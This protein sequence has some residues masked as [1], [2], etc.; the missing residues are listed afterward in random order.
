MEKFLD[1]IVGFGGSAS[2]PA[3]TT[4]A[5]KFAKYFKLYYASDK[6]EIVNEQENF[7]AALTRL[8][9]GVSYDSTHLGIRTGP[10]GISG[11]ALIKQHFILHGNFNYDGVE[12]IGD[13]DSRVEL[14]NEYGVL[15]CDN[16]KPWGDGTYPPDAKNRAGLSGLHAAPAVIN[17]E[18]ETALTGDLT[19]EERVQE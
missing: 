11:G 12:I 1:L 13:V 8:S 7:I 2:F 16:G 18:L 14:R 5:V 19:N 3:N 17:P 4:V 15:I 6:Y 9:V 10:Q